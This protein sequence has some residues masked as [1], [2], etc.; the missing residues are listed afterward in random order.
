[1][2]APV[3]MT[4]FILR[5]F[6]TRYNRWSVPVYLLM[7]WQ[8]P[9][10]PLR[11]RVIAVAVVGSAATLAG[12]IALVRVVPLTGGYSVKAAILFAA[13]ATVVVL[14]VQGHH[15]FGTFGPANHVTTARA[16]IVA[17]LA[18]LVG[19]GNVPE[20]AA[21]AAG[22][23]ALATA[24]DGVDGWLARRTGM[25]S[26]FGARYDMEIDALLILVL[27][28]LAW[29]LDK[30]GAWIVVAGMMRY[31]FVAAG[32][33]WRWMN[34]PLPPS[35]RR[36]A[37]CVVQIVGLAVVVSPIASGAASFALAAATLAALTW[38]F[39]VDVFWL[40]RHGA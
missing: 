29:Q 27:A 18:A 23:G 14:R 11:P 17:L 35:T 1:M 4:Q 33:V 6:R 24:L 8:L 40:R 9:E 38:S 15:P 28:V 16:V 19:E 20:T 34:T 25:A 32:L 36:K 37:V 5:P 31:L 10:R 7:V 13:M 39:A 3:E 26:T 21:L 12:A 30:A 2:R 22:G